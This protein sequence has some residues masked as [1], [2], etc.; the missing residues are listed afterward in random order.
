MRRPAAAGGDE[1]GDQP[2]VHVGGFGRRNVLGDQDMGFRVV[3]RGG[4]HFK[5]GGQGQIAQDSGADIADVPG[6]FP[7]HR[8]V[9]LAHFLAEAFDGPEGRLFNADQVAAQDGVDVGQQVRVFQQHE[10]ERHDFG[11]LL[12]E[13]GCQPLLHAFHLLA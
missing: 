11:M 13:L 12:A 8:V 10:V 4:L 3:D 6:A 7:Q 2:G 1:S 9:F 5:R